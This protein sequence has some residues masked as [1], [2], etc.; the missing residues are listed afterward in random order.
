[1]LENGGIPFTAEEM[2]TPFTYIAVVIFIDIFGMMLMFPIN[3]NL[4]E[5]GHLTHTSLKTIMFRKN[6]RMSLATNKDLSSSEIDSIIMSDPDKRWD[7]LWEMSQYIEAPCE[8][9]AGL[10]MCLNSVGRYALVG[11]SINFAYLVY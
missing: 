1:M 5:T 10:W 11:Y 4:V 9:L 7:V 2:V 6:F 8:I 3:Y